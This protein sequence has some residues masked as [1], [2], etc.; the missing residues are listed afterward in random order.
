MCEFISWKEHE[1]KNYFLTNADLETKDGAKLL[2]SDVKADLCGHG[3]IENYYPELKGKGQNKECTDFSTP[4]NFPHEIVNA[5]KLGKL[6]KI[7]ICLNVLNKRGNAE[8]NKITEPARAEY[9]KI[10]ETAFSKIVR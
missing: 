6:S 5:I 10:T 2:K 1:G 3:A 4:K 8:K 7:G 9:N